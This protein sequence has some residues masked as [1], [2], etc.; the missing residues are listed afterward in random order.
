MLAYSADHYPIW[1][2][3][4]DKPDLPFG[5]FG[6][7]PSLAASWKEMLASRLQKLQWVDDSRRLVGPNES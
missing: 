4:L 6:E 1:R 2:S 5:A 7:I 3:E